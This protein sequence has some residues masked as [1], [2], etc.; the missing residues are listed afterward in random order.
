L[1]DRTR[2]DAYL[3]IPA[4]AA[5]ALFLTYLADIATQPFFR[6]LVA[7]PL[8]YDQ[9]AKD[10]LNG[11]PSTQPFFL[12]PLYPGL[13]A[14]T[15]RL[16]DTSRMAVAVF[17]GALAAI[18]VYLVGL[19]GSRV[20]D[21]KVGLISAFLMTFYWSFYYFAGELVP[22][23]L[24]VTAALAATLG[25][26]SH[27]TRPHPLVV[28]A[29][30][31]GGAGFAGHLRVVSRYLAGTLPAETNGLPNLL[32]FMV[33]I[34][35]TGGLL[36]LLA[37][38][39]RLRS[40]VSVAISGLT[41]GIATLIWGG[42]L[43]HMSVLTGYV[44]GLRSR[45]VIVTWL[46]GIAIPLLASIAHNYAVS[47]RLIPLT[48][49][50]GVNLFIGNNPASDGMDPF[51]LGEGDRVRI[52]ADRLG[53]SGPER[54]AFFR[55]K[56]IDFIRSQPF[57]WLNL[58]GRKLLISLSRFEIDNNADISERKAVWRL[59]KIPLLNFGI[60]LPLTVLGIWLGI[61][62]SRKTIV[63]G[64]AFLSY[65]AVCITFFACERFRLPGIAMLL[66]VSAL[67][68]SEI[69]RLRLRLPIG[70]LVTA[71]AAAVLAN[72]DFL[73]IGNVE[74]PSITVNKAYVARLNGDYDQAE[75]LALEALEREP[76]N[77]GAC[78]QLAA[79]AEARG[80]QPKALR[81][82][83]DSLECDPFFY[84]SYQGARRLLGEAHISPSY[85]DAFVNALIEGKPTVALRADIERYLDQ[86]LQQ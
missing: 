57:R 77:A 13:I 63:L 29:F 32:F 47:G 73:G 51:R 12:S 83:L 46:V 9:Q 19:I 20:F 35:G 56:A 40:L 5:F 59:A 42:S 70:L 66:P 17:Q 33:F 82:F 81:F 36:A 43:I 75:Q 15:Y 78:F 61:P 11:L 2:F 72:V 14:T 25:V 31:V 8:V 86:R 37:A 71:G 48:T 58:I 21:R 69:V 1:D 50:A 45:R 27:D 3:L 65:I 18:N 79:I 6:F 44:L 85:I 34:G 52:E 53:L 41:A 49:S 74:F 55:S 54:S 80:D 76:V 24:S 23:T 60:V 4:L 30:L 26:L 38:R 22:A 84:A 67:G 7:N 64:L 62:R 68:L 39:V 16:A 10:L 28:V